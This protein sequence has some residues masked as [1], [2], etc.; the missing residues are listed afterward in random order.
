MDLKKTGNRTQ[1]NR[2]GPD[3]RLRLRPFWDGPV[4]GCHTQ[5]KWGNREKTGCN[6]SQ[7][8]FVAFPALAVFVL[9]ASALAAFAFATSTLA[10]SALTLAGVTH[11]LVLVLAIAFPLVLTFTTVTVAP[12]A[13]M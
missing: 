9:A 10:A 12:P 6:R 13:A 2:K 8:A 4:A 3:F 1:P 11:P 7:P 5:G